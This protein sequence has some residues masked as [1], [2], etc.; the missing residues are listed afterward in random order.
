MTEVNAFSV[1]T[2]PIAVKTI[3]HAMAEMH[4]RHRT[5]LNVLGVEDR[6]IAAVFPR[7]PDHRK[8]P[9]V[10]LGSLAAALDEYRLGDGVAGG[11]EI[12]AEPLALAIDMDDARE[13][14]EHR[15]IG[16]GAGVP[17]VA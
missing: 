7:A 6:E 9:A 1:R 17:A 3:G 10:A 15:Q 5:G 8:Q 16:I 11:Q 14:P 4:Q 2:Y 13:R 12:V